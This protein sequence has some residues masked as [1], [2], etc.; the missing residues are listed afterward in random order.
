MTISQ[1]L[2]DPSREIKVPTTRKFD[3]LS[4]G[5]SRKPFRSKVEASMSFTSSLHSLTLSIG[6]G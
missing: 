5:I 1:R 2:V 6:T 4:V 3:I